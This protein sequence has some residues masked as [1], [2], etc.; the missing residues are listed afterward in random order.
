MLFLLKDVQGQPLLIAQAGT[1]A[2]ADAFG[3]THFPEFCGESV[4]LDSRG[5]DDATKFRGVRKVRVPGPARPPVAVQTQI[6]VFGL[7]LPEEVEADDLLT[8]EDR[9]D[10]ALD[11]IARTSNFIWQLEIRKSA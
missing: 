3:R 2:E 7:E 6:L 10:L 8:P 1:Q 4:A 9:R 5:R 11:H